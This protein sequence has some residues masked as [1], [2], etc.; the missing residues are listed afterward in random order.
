MSSKL[1]ELRKKAGLTQKAL[2]ERLGVTQTQVSKYEATGNIPTNLWKPWAYALGC[3][4]D[5]LLPDYQ[6]DEGEKIFDFDNSLYGP[7]TKKLNLLLQYIDGSPHLIEESRD[8][9]ISPTVEQFGDRVIAFKEKPWVVLTGHFDAGKSHLC[10]FYLEGDRLP[11]GYRPVTKFPTFIRHI[12]DRPK[13]WFKEDLWLMKPGF[14]TDP[15]FAPEKWNDKEYCEKY[16]DLAG[17]WDTLQQHATLKDENNNS[18]EGAVLAFVDA[19]LLHSCVLVDLPGYDDKVTNHEVVDRLGRLASILLYLCP[20]Q[21]FLDEGDLTCLGHLLRAI[22]RYKEIDKNFPTLGNL[23][24]IASHSHPG[25]KQDQLEERILEGGSK[26]FY[27]HFKGNLL[28]TLSSGGQSISREDIQARFFSFYQEIPG[29]R[30]R[31]E[32]DLKLLL[33]KHMPLIRKTIVNQGILKFKK[34]AP[35]IYA[36]EIDK[37]EKML[38]D[39]EEAKRLCE[40]LEKEEPKRKKRHDREVKRIEQEFIA[41]RDEDLKNLRTVFKKETKVEKLEAMI[42]KRYKSDKKKAQEQASA[43][44]FEEIQSKVE[45]FRVPLVDKTSNLIKEFVENYN[46]EIGKLGSGG[47]GES[48]TPFDTR[49]AFVGGLAALSTLGA[50]GAWA[51]TLGNLGGYVIVTKGVSALSALGISFATTGGTAGVTGFVSAIGGPITLALGLAVAVGA[52]I[53]WLFGESWE[54]RLA[55][56]IKDVFEKEDVLSKFEDTIKA[57]W[58]ETRTAFKKGAD[59]LDKQCKNYL[60]ELKEIKNAFEDKQEEDPDRQACE[61]KVESCKEIKSFFA[62]IPWRRE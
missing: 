34:E 24:I 39:M 46:K 41:F 1:T 21:G 17:S 35:N 7:L 28:P 11:T 38:R 20:A 22:P 52:F 48:S 44:V 3:T 61:K 50:L 53:S 33:G 18:D 16:R 23:F 59:S 19:P 55:K 25:I 54:R 37:Y 4:V 62:A 43:Y 42:E 40:T 32:E 49:G 14:L 26:S 29:R 51:A 57:F 15:E 36:K 10:N 45:H 5:D 31:L 27:E 13:E 58:R 9:S 6:P 47:I 30:K 56:K 8:V 12:D 2:A 60:K